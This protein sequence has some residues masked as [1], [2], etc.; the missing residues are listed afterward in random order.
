MTVNTGDKDGKADGSDFEW[1]QIAT[2]TV[3]GNTIDDKHEPPVD[4]SAVL[5]VKDLPRYGSVPIV[6]AVLDDAR[7]FY[8]RTLRLG[9]PR[10]GR[11]SSQATC[12]LTF[13][14]SRLGISD[15]VDLGRS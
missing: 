11:R 12:H 8:A 15:H 4:Q 1:W 9:N 2:H 3:W 10:A 13:G 5:L 6:G 7:T 14:A